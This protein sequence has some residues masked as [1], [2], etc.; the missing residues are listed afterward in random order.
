MK[1]GFLI[2]DFGSQYTW[3]IARAFREMAFYSEV[4]PYDEPLE[5][6]RQKNPLGI[7]ISG[8]PSSVLEDSAPLR[9][10]EELLSVAPVLAVC[11]GDADGGSSKRRKNF[12][13]SEKNLWPKPYPLGEGTDP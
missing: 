7:V 3:L 6:L 9:S 2:F 4:L 1:R 5:N 11:Y 8:G 13:I 12:P 10:V